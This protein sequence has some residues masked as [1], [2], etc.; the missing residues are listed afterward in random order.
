MP[1]KYRFKTVIGHIFEYEYFI[2]RMGKLIVTLSFIIS[3]IILGDWYDSLR[4][5]SMFPTTIGFSAIGLSVLVTVLVL[6]TAA[7]SLLMPHLEPSLRPKGFRKARDERT[8]L[9]ILLVIIV[10][11]TIASTTVFLL[12][13]SKGYEGLA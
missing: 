11:L 8:I 6:L 13:I 5:Y 2:E 4:L 9:M 12:S 3:V 1:R 7:V 10:I